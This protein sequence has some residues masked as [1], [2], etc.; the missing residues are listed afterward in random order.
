MYVWV[1]HGSRL[2]WYLCWQTS[3][4][5]WC[6]NKIRK[7]TNSDKML[8]GMWHISP[9]PIMMCSLKQH[10]N[11]CE[12]IA[13]TT[14]LPLSPSLNCNSV[15][16]LHHN[17]FHWVSISPALWK[18]WTINAEKKCPVTAFPNILPICAFLTLAAS[19]GTSPLK[20]PWAWHSCCIDNQL[21]ATLHQGPRACPR[22]AVN[23][24]N[25]SSPAVL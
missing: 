2:T 15:R 6:K 11:N 9:P 12:A 17:Y 16:H 1:Q 5:M 23:V 25:T 10:A 8:F 7:H 4:N 24:G 21:F 20:Y 19:H 3:H 18:T 14:E 22:A 13:A